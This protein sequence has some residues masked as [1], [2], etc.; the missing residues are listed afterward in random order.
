[1]K[2]TTGLRGIARPVAAIAEAAIQGW[3]RDLHGRL[4]GR[5][6]IVLVALP[7][8]SLIGCATTLIGGSGTGSSRPGLAP[9]SGS[10][11]FL[12][13][14]LAT[15]PALAALLT[16]TAGLRALLTTSGL[17]HWLPRGS[18]QAAALAMLTGPM[19]ALGLPVAL[20]LDPPRTVTAAVLRLVGGAGCAA[21]G[22]VA[23][24][25]LRATLRALT[26]M[27]ARIRAVLT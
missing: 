17:P 8:T 21:V 3:W 11:V 2:F 12:A 19:L 10:V 24:G 26:P 18:I 16:T 25:L 20:A 14:G 4:G 1:M 15:T 9:A 5:A 22:L 7:I 13:V 23:G 6:R 27:M